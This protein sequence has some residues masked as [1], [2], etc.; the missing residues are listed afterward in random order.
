MDYGITDAEV[1]LSHGYARDLAD[2]SAH[3]QSII[4]RVAGERNNALVEVARLRRELAARDAEL[5]V[6]RFQSR[7][8][9]LRG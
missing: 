7:R 2:V 8:A 5:R 9:A 3:A 4:D 1:G 6:L